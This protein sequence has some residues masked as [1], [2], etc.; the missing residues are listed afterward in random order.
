MRRHLP[1]HACTFQNAYFR[2]ELSF[3]EA[4]FYTF[5]LE[6]LID[7]NVTRTIHAAAP[8]DPLPAGPQEEYEQLALSDA[9][10]VVSLYNS[11]IWSTLYR[12]LGYGKLKSFIV[13]YGN[14]KRE[15]G[16]RLFKYC[17]TEH[18]D[19]IIARYQEQTSEIDN[20]D[21]LCSAISKMIGINPHSETDSTTAFNT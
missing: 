5:V 3:V 11:N 2:T 13:Q 1:P 7:Q 12:F 8:T 9:I 17:D 21:L 16:N 18:I 6:D 20:P 19:R 14:A 15:K 4:L 10:A